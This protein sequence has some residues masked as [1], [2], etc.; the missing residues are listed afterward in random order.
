[1]PTPLITTTIEV[2]KPFYVSK[3]LIVNAIIAI[4]AL[5]P[6]AQQWVSENPGITLMAVSA[7]GAALR[8][9]THGRVMLGNG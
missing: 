1:M 4:C 9:V 5:V 6:A 2:S 3:T 8:L 7:I